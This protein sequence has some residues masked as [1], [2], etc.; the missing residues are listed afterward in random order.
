MTKRDRILGGMLGLVVGD[1]LGLPATGL[2]RNRLRGDPVTE[3]RGDGRNPAGTWSDDSSMALQTAASLAERGYDP[4]DMMERFRRWIQLGEMT[5][6][7]V[8][9]GVGGTTLQSVF[10]YV[11]AEMV[12]L[13]QESW[14]GRDEGDNGNGS[15]MRILPVALWLSEADDEEVIA[16]AG[17]VSALTHAHVRS[18]LCCAYH[19]LVVREII[20]G[21]PISAAMEKAGT[22]LVL[23]VPKDERPILSPFLSGTILEANEREIETSGY[24]VHTLAASLWCCARNDDFR[25]AV[26]EAVN[27]GY[28]ADT[29]GAVVGGLAGAMHGIDSIPSEWIE[30]LQA[31]ERVKDVVQRFSKVAESERT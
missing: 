20:A 10:R 21:K 26:L 19:C 3:I 14:G 12:G 25:D 16:K 1:A 4:V 7:G 13:S 22:A 17:E 24:V 9:W 30:A 8:A 31:V 27:L 28:D 11:N 23:H 29:T 2:T 18:R 15:L 6:H 5:P